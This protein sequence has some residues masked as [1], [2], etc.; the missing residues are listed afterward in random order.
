MRYNRNCSLLR[1]VSSRLMTVSGP[2]MSYCF[3]YKKDITI[4][5][6]CDSDYRLTPTDLYVYDRKGML[7]LF[8]YFYFLANKRLLDNCQNVAGNDPVVALG[9]DKSSMFIVE[10]L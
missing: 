6:F 3:F 4:G 9:C 5:I 7:H 8:L 2:V 1:R 10:T